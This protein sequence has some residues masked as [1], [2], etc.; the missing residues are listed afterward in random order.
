MLI[1]NIGEILLKNSHGTYYQNF[2]KLFHI[3][4]LLRESL[5]CHHCCWNL[6]WMNILKP[7][8]LWWNGNIFILGILYLEGMKESTWECRSHKKRGQGGNMLLLWPC[9]TFKKKWAKFYFCRRERN[10]FS[11]KKKLLASSHI[12][13]YHIT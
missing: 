1:R 9:H 11:S 5:L 8:P 4:T 7:W 10:I 6:I 2:V 12:I 3:V 13:S